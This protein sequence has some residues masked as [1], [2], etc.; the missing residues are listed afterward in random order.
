[1]PMPPRVDTIRRQRLPAF[2]EFVQDELAPFPGRASTTTRMVIASVIML[3][4]VMTFRLPNAAVG[5]Y[6][7]LNIARTRP[8]AAFRTLVTPILAYTAGLAVYVTGMGIFG[9]A[10]TLRFIFLVGLLFA[11]F[12]VMRTVEN[13][14][15]AAGFS[16]M[17][18]ASIPY[19]ERPLSP[20]ANVEDSLWTALAVGV[21]TAV[22]VVVKSVAANLQPK[23]ELLQGLA[24]RIDAVQALFH[25]CAEHGKADAREQQ[26]TKKLAIVGTGGLRRLLQ[27]RDNSYLADQDAR[28]RLSAITALIDRLV[29]VSA[30]LSHT[31]VELSL[32]DRNRAQRIVEACATLRDSITQ[33]RFSNVV[34]PEMERAPST[35]LPLLSEVE[36]TINLIFE[37]FTPAEPNRRASATTVPRS[38]PFRIFIPDAFSNREHVR[39]ALKGCF[40]TTLCYLIYLGIAW[41]GISTC[42]A[43][44]IVTALSNI[45]SS[46]QKQFLRIGGAVTG[47]VIGLGCEIFL[48][49]QMD[50]ITPFALLVASVSALASW[51]ALS[52]P[53][54]SYFGLQLGF[55][56][57]L[58]TVHDFAA[59][60]SLTIAR[61]RIAGVLLGL[62]V[63]WLVFD[64]I[65]PS[66]AIL[67]MRRKLASNLRLLA[68]LVRIPNHNGA[69]SN[70]SEFYSLREQ[71]VEGFASVSAY[72]DAVQFEFGTQR[73]NHLVLRERMLRCQATAETLFLSIL[74]YV[75][76]GLSG[77]RENSGKDIYTALS[78]EIADA[79]VC[80]SRIAEICEP[81]TRDRAGELI[82]RAEQRLCM[83]G[84]VSQDDGAVFHIARQLVE[85]TRG[86]LDDVVHIYS[87]K[88]ELQG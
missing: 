18:A 2:F 22:A 6:Y 41:P 23:N 19:W 49:P 72:A 21:G 81:E 61:D 75:Q 77:D 15:A 25:S 82:S 73:E 57:Y 17:I 53:R 42:V 64:H 44:C 35:T 50:S 34:I 84:L 71:I 24:A 13:Y 12:F 11:V 80:I 56:F 85:L 54:F 58:V 40:A 38:V 5:C 62:I 74:G 48:F 27:Q 33:R 36:R 7:V 79:L 3:F 65:W 68:S 55:A 4:L 63:M 67:E 16:F 87:R 88:P 29:D 46:R 32:E 14:S 76:V 70:R 45:G 52:S 30:H 8:G 59:P 69:L 60:T 83:D 37:T 43:T 51:I 9:N 78:E 47:G 1:M 86:S 39:Y 10:D 66:P 26:T 28:A 20:S 31:A